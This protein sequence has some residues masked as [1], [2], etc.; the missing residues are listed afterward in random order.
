[1]DG[2]P[3]T[4]CNG[5]GKMEISRWV[6]RAAL[7]YTVILVV[8]AGVAVLAGS[9]PKNEPG[10]G[11]VL[12]GICAALLLAVYWL[13][14]GG[15]FTLFHRLFQFYR[16]TFRGEPPDCRKCAGKGFLSEEKGSP[17]VRKVLVVGVGIVVLGLIAAWILSRG[18]FK[19]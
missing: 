13:E 15:I 19:V 9:S 7:P 8:S 3:C 16:W 14:G 18:Y 6:R 2:A 17:I 10:D 1:M 11:F 4:G 12:G 5:S